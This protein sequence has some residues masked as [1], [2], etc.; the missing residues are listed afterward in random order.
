MIVLITTVNFAE[1]AVS[2]S[3]QSKQH[4]FVVSGAVVRDVFPHAFSIQ[5]NILVLNICQIDL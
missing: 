1:K 2:F 4:A 3:N 5:V